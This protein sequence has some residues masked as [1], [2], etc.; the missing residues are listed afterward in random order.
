MIKVGDVV[1]HTQK[2]EGGLGMVH[3]IFDNRAAVTW[4]YR[5]PSWPSCLLLDIAISGPEKS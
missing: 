4:Q 2:P 1:I 3:A 5:D